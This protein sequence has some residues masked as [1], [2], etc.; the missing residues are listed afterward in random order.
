MTDTDPQG[1]EQDPV[2]DAVD[3]PPSVGEPADAG[4]A[5]P[6]RLLPER[7]LD[8]VSG[9]VRTDALIEAYLDLERQ[10][11]Q[12]PPRD[13]PDTADDYAIALQGDLF[14]VDPDLN[15]KLHA[16]GFDQNQAQ[17]V[18]D[19][20]AQHLLPMV[21][22]VASAYEAESQIERLKHEFGG[23]KA[24]RETARQIA[25]WGRSN[26]AADVYD[27]LA[28]SR[29]GV[30]AMHKMMA[31]VE[32]PLLGKSDPENALPTEAELKDM[33]RD[34]RYWREQDRTFVEK[35]RDGFRQIYDR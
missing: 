33:M 3:R 4:A 7:F 24:W 15:R 26:L 34:P 1:Q 31:G 5:Q 6:A 12:H 18:Y 9:T 2:G 29:E 16:A 13:V 35:V 25:V 17:L 21:A 27:V 20:A 23:E 14:T 11:E 8:D 10:L 19:L 28:A 30:L 32:P 22:E